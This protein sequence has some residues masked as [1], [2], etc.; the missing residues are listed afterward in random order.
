LVEVAN[1]ILEAPPLKKRPDW[2][3]AT[4][5]LPKAK[6]SGSTYVLWLLSGLVKGSLLIWVN[7][8]PEAWETTRVANVA[9]RE[10]IRAARMKAVVR[11]MRQR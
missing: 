4:M 3:V 7:V 1:P 5:V 9:T 11:L 10:R 2:K 6:V 8:S